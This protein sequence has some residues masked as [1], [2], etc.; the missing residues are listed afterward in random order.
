MLEVLMLTPA[1]LE[2]GMEVSLQDTVVVFRMKEKPLKVLP[3]FG[4]WF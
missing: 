4:Y 2:T 1:S 3:S